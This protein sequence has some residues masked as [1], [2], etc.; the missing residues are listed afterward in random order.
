MDVYRKLY[1]VVII[2]QHLQTGV[3]DC[4]KF[5]KDRNYKSGL[6]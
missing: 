6:L 4:H 1:D 5:W 3:P 2:Q